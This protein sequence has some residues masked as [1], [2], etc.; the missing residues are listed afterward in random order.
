M[1][2]MKE[3]FMLFLPALTASLLILLV[4]SLISF[5]LYWIIVKFLQLIKIDAFFEPSDA[6]E[7]LKKIGIHKPLSKIIAM[8]FI[9]PIVFVVLITFFNSLGLEAVSD[10]FGDVIALIPSMIIALILLIVS[11]LMAYG[12]GMGLF[13]LLKDAI[14]PEQAKTVAWIGGSLVLFGLSM[15][16]VLPQLGI[17]FF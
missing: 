16:Y 6:K 4:G 8:L 1:D 12:V 14:N 2:S 5:V 3:R 7:I 13:V 11:G 10:F 9:S 15:F 17:R